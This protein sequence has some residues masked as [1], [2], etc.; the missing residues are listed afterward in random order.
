[1]AT[2][3]SQYTPSL[4]ASGFYQLAAPYSALISATLQYTCVGVISIQGAIAQGID[5][6]NTVYIASGDTA[7]SYASDLKNGVSLI[8]I[9]SGTGNLVQFPNSAMLAVP[10]V[11]G[12]IYRNLVLGIA[13]SAL[14]DSMDTTVLQQEVSDLIYSKIGVRSTTFV[15]TVGAAT[16][17]T[18]AQDAAV[19]A[20]RAAV[21]TNPTSTYYQ[22]QLLTNENTAL[23]A[24]VAQLEAYIK[25]T[26]PPIPVFQS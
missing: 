25:T 26:I 24:K 15:T 8:T 7:A 3:T 6:L 11:N 10:Q 14:P 2:L 17:L 19:S 20:A 16:V 13:L 18:T 23:L 12:I 21:I 1:M 5:V 4:N 9:T 22:N